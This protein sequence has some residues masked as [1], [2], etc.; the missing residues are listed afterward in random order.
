MKNLF[1]S[2]AFLFAFNLIYWMAFTYITTDSKEDWNWIESILI[3]V[4][5]ASFMTYI[6]SQQMKNRQVYLTAGQEEELVNYLEAQGYIEKKRKE[7]TIFFKKQGVS[8]NPFRYTTIKTSPF[9]T[10]LVAS[11]SIVE[12]IPN[13]LIPIKSK[14]QL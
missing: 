1:K 2:V 6:F 14:N 9:Y 10:L 7:S 3:S 5:Y 8:F 4:G 13:H 11:E 12:N